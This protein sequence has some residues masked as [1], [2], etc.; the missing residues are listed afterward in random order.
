MA[1][2]WTDRKKAA[3]ARMKYHRGVTPKEEARAAQVQFRN[4]QAEE[5]ALLDKLENLESK[6]KPEKKPKVEKPDKKTVV[7]PKKKAKVEKKDPPKFGKHGHDFNSE[8]D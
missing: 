4:D 1:Y 5:Q 6:M 2:H 7:K 3:E 8:E